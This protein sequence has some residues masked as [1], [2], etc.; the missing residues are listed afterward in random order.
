MSAVGAPGGLGG[1]HAHTF[2]VVDLLDGDGG[3]LPGNVVEADAGAALGHVDDRLLTQLAG[4][5][6]HAPSVVAVG[7]RKERGLSELPAEPLAGQVV[8][9]QLRHVPSQTAGD[10]LAHGEGTAQHFKGV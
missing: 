8:I 1:R 10:V 2:V 7:G 3:A 9:V 5:P 6:G 4:R